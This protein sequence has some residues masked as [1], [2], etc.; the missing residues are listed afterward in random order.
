MSFVE[1]ASYIRDQLRVMAVMAHKDGA[2][3]LVYFLEMACMEA[4]D[5]VKL[6]AARDRDWLILT[7]PNP[8]ES[9]AS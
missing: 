2:E 8:P 7:S 9:A 4:D 5:L 3:R 1:T 6:S